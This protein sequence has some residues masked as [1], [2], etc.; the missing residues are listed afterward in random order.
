MPRLHETITTRLPLDET[1]AFIADFANSARWDPGTASSERAD[2]RPPGPGATYRLGV[3][4]GKRV[5]PMEYR[6]TGWEPPTRVVLHG[7]GSGV[8]ATDDIRFA[9][10]PDGTVVDYTADIRLTGWR[11]LLEPFAGGAFER[12]AANAA[13]GM[14]EALEARSAS[15]ATDAAGPA[16]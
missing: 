10:T 5:A 12:L 6:I 4:M 8:D 13:A 3:R 7:Q 1:F 11:R 14:R 15:G 9:A 16:R 2:D